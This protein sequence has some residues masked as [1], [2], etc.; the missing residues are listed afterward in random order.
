MQRRRMFCEQHHS[1]S[2]VEPTESD[3]LQLPLSCLSVLW[4][5]VVQQ[6]SFKHTLSTHQTT[7][8]GDFHIQ[9]LGL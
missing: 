1:Q 3:S 7:P 9:K 5:S 4:T 6:T 8:L 2:N